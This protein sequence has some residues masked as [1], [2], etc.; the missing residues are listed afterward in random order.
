M[1]QVSLSRRYEYHRHSTAWKISTVFAMIRKYGAELARTHR[2]HDAFP[3][4]VRV[5]QGT[6]QG[7]PFH[8]TLLRLR[9]GGPVGFSFAWSKLFY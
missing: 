6:Q 2:R 5:L 8:I 1:T 9:V 4:L 7:T 3:K